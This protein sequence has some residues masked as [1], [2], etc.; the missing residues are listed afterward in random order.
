MRQ[1]KTPLYPGTEIH[2]GRRLLLSY[3]ILGMVLSTNLLAG[4]SV[5]GGGIAENN[6]LYAYQ[7][8]DKLSNLCLQSNFCQLTD[9]EKG[10]LVKVLSSYPKEKLT[11][12][13]IEFRSEKTEPGFFLIDGQV[14]MAKTGYVIGSTIY[15]N[16][17]L[18]YSNEKHGVSYIRAIDIPQAVSMLVHEMGHHQGEADHTALD[19][20]GAK[21]Q[22][23]LRSHLQEVDMG[24][25]N[26]TIFATTIDFP[27]LNRS[28]IIL[29]DQ[30]AL[31]NVTEVVSKKLECHVS[32]EKVLGYSFWNLHWNRRF[33][34]SRTKTFRYPLRARVSM[35][36]GGGL[37]MEL[38]E[39]DLEIVLM[40]ER[41]D[42]GELELIP[43]Q[44]RVT[45]IDCTKSPISCH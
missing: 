19:L 18:L 27:G 30:K 4:D 26:R 41:N 22:T 15:F 43:D 36:C 3:V 28:E 11:E 8:L 33:L 21:V 24:P 40:F 42:K 31:Y 16:I 23:V 9:K 45:Q 44:Y 32:G 20:L 7:N 25:Y 10:I 13:Q 1:L 12:K 17:D 34:D 14:R 5:G 2:E 37:Q 38:V 29:R 35:L 6:I 39:D